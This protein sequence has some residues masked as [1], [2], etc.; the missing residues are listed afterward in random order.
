MEEQCIPTLDAWLLVQDFVRRKLNALKLRVDLNGVMESGQQ[1]AIHMSKTNLNE[2]N[3]YNCYAVSIV[4]PKIQ[5][6]SEN[7]KILLY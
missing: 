2:I 5:I 7:G 4:V 1:T 6:Q 3:Y